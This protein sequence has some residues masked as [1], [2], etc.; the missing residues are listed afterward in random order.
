MSDAPTQDP[1]GESYP[2]PM[3]G[4]RDGPARRLWGTGV[5]GAQGRAGKP[6]RSRNHTCSPR[7][8][9]EVSTVEA[10]S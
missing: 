9:F 1:A 4:S 3:P 2:E 8:L 7:P 5:L 10:S 6:G